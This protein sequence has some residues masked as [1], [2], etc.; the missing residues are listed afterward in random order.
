MKKP[1]SAAEVNALL[2]RTDLPPNTRL[3]IAE[4]GELVARI[5]R[6]TGK[7]AFTRPVLPDE[8]GALAI[9]GAITIEPEAKDHE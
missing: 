1:I 3:R 2:E 9:Q 7:L 5:D 8:A 4:T 6:K